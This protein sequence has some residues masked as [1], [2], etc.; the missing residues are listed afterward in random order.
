VPDKTLLL[1]TI[2]RNFHSDLVAEADI[3]KDIDGYYQG[4]LSIEN[5]SNNS[6]IF[7]QGTGCS[8]CD[9]N[10]VVQQ[11]G[12]AA[13]EASQSMGADNLQLSVK[14]VKQIINKVYFDPAFRFAGGTALQMQIYQ[15]CMGTYKPIE[16][17]K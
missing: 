12:V 13:N 15:V 9:A 1:Q 6:V 16:P 5:I 8:N 14:Q 7:S 3:I 11:I 2:A 10:Q 4:E 17:L